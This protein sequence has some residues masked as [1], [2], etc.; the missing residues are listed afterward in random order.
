M[1]NPQ[2]KSDVDEQSKNGVSAEAIKQAL[3]GAGWKDEDVKEVMD[4]IAVAQA[5]AASGTG[6]AASPASS[7][8]FP[9]SLDVSGF[10]GKATNESPLFDPSGKGATASPSSTTAP[11][12][13]GDVFKTPA[14]SSPAANLGVTVS[15]SAGTSAMWKYVTYALGAVLVL[16]VGGAVYLYVQNTDIQSDGDTMA[17]QSKMLQ[18]QVSMLTKEKEDLNILVANLRTENKSLSSQLDVFAVSEGVTKDE[19]PV[20][21]KGSLVSDAGGFAVLTSSRVS[22]PIKNSKDKK[23]QASLSGLMGA[24]VQIEGTHVPGSPQINARSVNGTAIFDAPAPPPV[25][26]STPG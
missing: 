22:F 12:T 8:N 7:T 4:E 1:A 17:S 5:Q 25:S 26:T 18:G 6:P 20:V 3:S 15:S 21:V 24:I 16:T 19:V 9:S 14:S 2:L 11:A 23:V 10:G 13:F